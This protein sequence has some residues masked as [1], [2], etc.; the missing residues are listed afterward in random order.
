MDDEGEDFVEIP[1]DNEGVPMESDSDYE[2][3]EE[4]KMAQFEDIQENGNMSSCE[5]Y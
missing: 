4:E 3:T 1:D 5:N 2:E